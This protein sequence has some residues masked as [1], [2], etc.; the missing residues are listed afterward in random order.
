MTERKLALYSDQHNNAALDARVMRLIGR[1]APIL[2]YIACE[3]DPQ[4]LYFEDR[5]GFYGER[6]ARLEVYTGSD[7]PPGDQA[8][9]ALFR[10]DA[11]HLSGGNTYAF[12][13]W[14]RRRQLLAPLARYVAE[15]GVL[16]GVSAGAILMTPSVQSA[17]LCGDERDAQAQ[18]ETALGLVDFHF[19]P[20]FDPDADS[21]SLAVGLPGLYGCPDGAGIVVD[22]AT[23]ELHGSVQR[24]TA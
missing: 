24:L 23:I 6:G 16:I 21:A 20:H 19:W 5:R 17:A 3:P 22:G 18:D 9:A 10:C 1:P 2:G 12:L 7:L 11:I 4:R 15:G 13:H 8:W 14:L